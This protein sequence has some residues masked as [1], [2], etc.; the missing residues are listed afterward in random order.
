[1]ASSRIQGWAL[2]LSAYQYSIGYKAGKDLSNADALSRLPRPVTTTSDCL[3]GDLVQLL[4]HLSNSVSLDAV[5]IKE[6]SDKDTVLSRLRRYIL[7]GWPAR[8]D[9]E[10]LSLD[11]VNSVFCRVVY[12]GDL[13][14]S[15][16]PRVEVMF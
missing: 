3:P 2:A 14:W 5:T 12:C 6:Q 16:Q 11:K 13:G 9:E 4:A 1:M 10:D 7:S 15:Y 8:I